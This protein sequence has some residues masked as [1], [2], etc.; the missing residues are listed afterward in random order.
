MEWN[1]YREDFNGK[2]I[3]TFNVFAHIRFCE[4]VKKYRKKYKDSRDDFEKEL[5]SILFYYFGYKCEYEVVVTAWPPHIT[6]KE[7]ERLNEEYKNAEE[8][9]GHPPYSLW[10]NPEVGEKVDVYSQ[11]MLNWDIFADYVWNNAGTKRGE[12][13]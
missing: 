13:K 5:K 7:L 10:I 12:Q 9:Y 1:V 3:K 4:D 2:K 8:K 11:V 6:P